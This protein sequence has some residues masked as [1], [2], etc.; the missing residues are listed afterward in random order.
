MSM[1]L[2]FT[3]CWMMATGSGG[4]GGAPGAGG[5]ELCGAAGAVC[6]ATQAAQE[7][8]ASANQ[9]VRA[10]LAI[11]FLQTRACT[12]AVCRRAAKPVLWCEEIP[13]PAAAA[14]APQTPPPALLLRGVRKAFG[15]VV[16]VDGVDLE[17]ARG[18]CFGL[19]GPNGAGKTT[20][21]EMCEGLTAPDAGSISLLGLGWRH[22]ARELRQR[23]GIQLQETRLSDKLTVLETLRLFR[24]S[25][26]TASAWTTPS[27]PRSWRRS[28]ARAW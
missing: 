23:I 3:A 25:S 11:L 22:G 18:E 15:D 6:A 20:T 13:L 8:S 10:M 16:A 28:A 21:I 12:A 5:R 26:A 27:P 19:L 1:S 14:I 24:A 9:C 7:I 17:V 4:S 2:A